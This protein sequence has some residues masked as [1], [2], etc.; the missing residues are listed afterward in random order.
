[1]PDST[2]NGRVTLAVLQNDILHLTRQVERWYDEEQA[3]RAQESK[4]L[5]RLEECMDELYQRVAR[6][7]ERLKA[8]TGV[9][10]A[11]QVI[12]AAIAAAIG[13]SWK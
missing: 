7:E 9:L 8:T 12:L 1:M 4:R 13:V 10:G 2:P 11:L 3:W 6:N 5:Q